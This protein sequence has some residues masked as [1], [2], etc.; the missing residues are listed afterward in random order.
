M[1]ESYLQKYIPYILVLWLITAC[2]GMSPKTSF[3][4]TVGVDTIP[5][6][7][8]GT[9]TDDYGVRYT[10][11]DSVWLQHPDI[12][13]H[14]LK[15]NF[16]E[17]YVIARNGN[18]NPTDQGLYTRIDYMS[19]QGMAPYYWG[20]CLT[21]YKAPSDL[22]AEDHAAADRQNPKKGCNGFPFSRMKKVD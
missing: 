14:I 2:F 19:F 7:M 21:E 1:Y 15:W 5:S 18:G 4:I 11:N 12:R 16:T 22:A 13:Y 20:F 10:I 3:N 9:F 17:Q 8:K 6:S